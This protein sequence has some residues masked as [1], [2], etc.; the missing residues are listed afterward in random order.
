MD[1]A[2]AEREA[3]PPKYVVGIGASAGGLGALEA[4]LDDL[5]DVSRI[6][7]GKIELRRSMIDLRVTIEQAISVVRR[8]AEDADL[9]FSVEISEDRLVVDGDPARLEQVTVNLLTNAI[10]YTP[11]GGNIGLQLY[12]E[13]GNAVIE[14]QDSGAGIPA[15]KLD[16]IFSLFYQSDDTRNRSNGGMGV[17]L[18]LVKAVVEM[19]GGEVSATSSGKGLGSCFRVTIP[20]TT[21]TPL[22]NFLEVSPAKSTIN[23]VVLVEDIDDAR[24][25]L[26]ALL[27]LNGLEVHQARDGVEGLALI[28]RVQPDAGVIDIGLPGM[29]S[30]EVAQRLRSDPSFANLPLVALT[31]YG[32]DADREAVAAS[33]Y[34]LHLVKPL[35]PQKLDT[36]WL[37]LPTFG[38]CRGVNR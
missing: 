1:S 34:D 28:Q 23:S 29:D 3:A 22:R 35:N 33:G 13:D 17:G 6:T 38:S 15:D 30:H 19:H 12:G 11:S 24:E 26:A 21:H 37:S 25:M 32:Q 14:V 18:T 2:T 36:F 8:S 10:K 31:G 16:G 4:L 9:N 7:H 5:L 20:L 27:S